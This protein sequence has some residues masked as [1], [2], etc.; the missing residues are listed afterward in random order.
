MRSVRMRSGGS[1]YEFGR[2]R[3]DAHAR[4]LL[5]EGRP[6]ALPTK[7]FDL[8]LLL[9][10]NSGQVVTKEEL[11][12]QV[13]PDQ[14][15]EENNLTVRM[16][17]LRRALGE[18][19]GGQR[20]IETVPRLGYRFVARVREVED[21]VV[22][23]T[24]EAKPAEEGKISIAVLPLLNIGKDG[25]ME[26]LSDGITESII[27][28]L[29]QL[30]QLKVMARST[31]FRYKVDEVD[32]KQ[33]GRD[34]NVGAVLTGRV[35][36]LNDRLIIGMELVNCNDGSQ[37]W[38]EQFNRMPSDI[39]AVQEEIAKTVSL[40]LRLKLTSLEG[41]QLAKH[42]TENEEAYQLYL[43][44]RYFWNK[45]NE[46]SLRWAIEYFKQAIALDENFALAYS[47]LADAYQRISN[48]WVSPREVLSEALSASIKAV[49]LDDMLA[50]AHASLG[51]VKM[52]YN[53][54]WAGAERENRLAID[55]N[56]GSPLVH[57]LLGLRRLLMGR[58]DESQA[59]STL[60]QELDPLS[61][62][63]N[64][65]LGMIYYLKGQ[66]EPAAEQLHKV[67]D[68]EP[69]YFPAHFTLGWVNT[70]I[71][72]YAQAIKEFLVG[73]QQ[74][75]AHIGLGGAGHVHGLLGQRAEAQQ[76]IEKLHKIS[77]RE[78]VSP[79]SVAIIYAGLGDKDRAFEWLEKTYKERGD[80]LVWLKVAPELDSLRGD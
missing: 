31:V 43:K 76:I 38:G 22:A 33:V 51:L 20:Y 4:L 8:L 56:P 72:N 12:R 29:S 68:L 67:L 36:Q 48:V 57:Q 23:F 6:V 75:R 24:E 69:N 59:E 18:K 13:W 21:Q 34:M 49:E 11:M 44:G 62:Q 66:Y 37:I 52:Y 74:E 50:E 1:I 78:H 55:L 54:D 17:A 77:E 42:C 14:F 53:H 46:E 35:W 40:K 7:V 19:R 80:G 61:L 9:V 32:A 65:N 63:I 70:R 60:A 2:F 47:G 3:L 16:S 28:D 25:D 41:R 73:W 10:Q 15:V 45:F 26:Y 30:P 64:V 58:F 71:G 27:N 5:L 79:Y 39:L